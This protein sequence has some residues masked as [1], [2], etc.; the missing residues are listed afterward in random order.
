MTTVTPAQFEAEVRALQ[1]R[2]Q[3]GSRELI[4]VLA[5]VGKDAKEIDVPAGY[6][7]T[8]GADRQMRNWPRRSGARQTFD[9]RYDIGRDGASLEITPGRK[10]RGPISMLELGRT[11]RSAGSVSISIMGAGYGSGGLMEGPK[12]RRRRTKRTVGPMKAKG[13]WSDADAIVVRRFPWRFMQAARKKRLTRLG[14]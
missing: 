6:T 9:G 14:G 1:L 10:S 2:V 12:I 7:K 4:A 5:A 8:L 11:P 3:P 13:T